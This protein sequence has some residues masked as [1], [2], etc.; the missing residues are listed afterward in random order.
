MRN[1]SSH[2]QHDLGYRVA[3]MLQ[4]KK[5]G[6]RRL[7]DTEGSRYVTLEEI[8]ERVRMGEDL[9]VV[10]AK[11]GQDLTQVTL[12]QIILESRGAARLLPVSLLKQL[13]RMR[14]DALAEFFG[15]YVAWALE[16]YLQ[17]KGNAR[18]VVPWNPLADL[19]MPG[20]LKRWFGGNPP[21]AGE[22]APPPFPDEPPADSP[23][24][25]D[26]LAALRR[27]LAELRRTVEDSRPARKGRRP[28]S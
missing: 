7:Y 19:A 13:V 2:A 24:M 10:D 8:A 1:H 28:A 16:V 11:S 27:E 22:P 3:A 12:A 9:K 20:I 15:R 26:E 21:A 6:N 4:V 5:Y 23:D 17:L 14:D 25:T 18:A